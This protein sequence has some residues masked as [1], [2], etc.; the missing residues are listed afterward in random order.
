MRFCEEWVLPPLTRH[1]VSRWMGQETI[2]HEEPGDRV[3][4]STPFS[5]HSGNLGRPAYTLGS[6]EAS[7]VQ[8]HLRRNSARIL[9]RP[10]E[11]VSSPSL[12]TDV[13]VHRSETVTLVFSSKCFHK[14]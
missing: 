1:W 11:S 10:R 5:S 12:G 3:T 13:L 6:G 8:G 9:H 4:P 2:V 7:F 14:N